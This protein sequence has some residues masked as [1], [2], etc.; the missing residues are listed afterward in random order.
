MLV[1][2]DLNEPHGFAAAQGY[3][4]VHPMGTVRLVH[5]VPSSNK[6]RWSTTS[7][8]AASIA[9]SEQA[10]RRLAPSPSEAPNII[11]EVE[12][13]HDRNTAEAICAAAERFDAD[14]LCL[15]SHT[16]PGLKSK[17][18]GSVSLSV[19]QICR[20]PLLMVWPPQETM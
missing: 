14:V 6:L 13:T 7:D 8:P 5:N 10:L 19:M 15:G 3:S 12:I 17:M 16:R 2:V 9:A 18:L 1:A 11:T 4:I 20:R